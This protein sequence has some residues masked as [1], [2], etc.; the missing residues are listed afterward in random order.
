MAYTSGSG[1][2]LQSVS[3]LFRLS[4]AGLVSHATFLLLLKQ[5]LWPSSKDN[6]HSKRK[7]RILKKI[8][9]TLQSLSECILK[10]WMGNI[11]NTWLN[12]IRKKLEM[13]KVKLE[14]CLY[15]LFSGCYIL[16]YL[17]SLCCTYILIAVP[18]YSLTHILRKNNSNSSSIFVHIW[19]VLYDIFLI[20]YTNIRAGQ[21]I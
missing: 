12:Q 19:S 4:L 3:L 15:S 20:P 2:L 1:R 6:L 16:L 7:K 14:F 21:R 11:I 13:K 10:K 18:K 17:Y 8:L 9:I 5:L